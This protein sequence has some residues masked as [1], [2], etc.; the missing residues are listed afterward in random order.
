MKKLLIA[1]AF[2]TSLTSFAEV[3]LCKI[4]VDPAPGSMIKQGVFTLDGVKLFYSE[5]WFNT[6]NQTQ[7]EQTVAKQEVTRFDSCLSN[8]KDKTLV[9]CKNNDWR[10]PSSL[11]VNI[12]KTTHYSH[13][14][15]PLIREKK[16]LS[17]AIKRDNAVLFEKTDR[18]TF[19]CLN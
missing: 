1:L 19:N 9:T 15:S 10:D 17:L 16:E 6:Y 8:A 13:K 2:L 3:E 14:E 18:K 7:G 5:S 12:V 11:S 4:S